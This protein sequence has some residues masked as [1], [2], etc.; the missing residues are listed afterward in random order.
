MRMLPG[1]D[2]GAEL[3]YTDKREVSGVAEKKR[4]LSVRVAVYLSVGR[5]DDVLAEFD[6]QK[7]GQGICNYVRE[8]VRA[9]LSAKTGAFKK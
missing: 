8:L 9:D 7:G 5:D 2:V 3:R 6:R 4:A 1:A